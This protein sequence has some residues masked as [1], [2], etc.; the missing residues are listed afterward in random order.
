[1]PPRRRSPRVG[2]RASTAWPARRPGATSLLKC[3][4]FVQ[5]NALMRDRSEDDSLPLTQ[6]LLAE[7]LGVQRPT[8]TNAVRELQRAGLVKPGRQR[9]TIRNRR[10]LMGEVVNATSWCAPALLDTYPKP[11]RK[12]RADR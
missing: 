4:V 1:M 12:T 10:G 5:N 2:R 9:V 3:R 6:G 7:M 8:I 11:S